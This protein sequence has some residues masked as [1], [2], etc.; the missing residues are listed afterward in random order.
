MLTWQELR[1][2]QA[3]FLKDLDSLVV[4]LARATMYARRQSHDEEVLVYS[5]RIRLHL[6]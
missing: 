6:V 1:V 4:A 5:E 2:C 3:P